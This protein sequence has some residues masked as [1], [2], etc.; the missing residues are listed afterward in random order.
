M[1][2]QISVTLSPV[3]T[4]ESKKATWRSI[5]DLLKLEHPTKTPKDVE[6]IIKRFRNLEYH[7][8]IAIRNHQQGLTETGNLIVQ[9]IK[10]NINGLFK[11]GGPATEVLG[12]MFGPR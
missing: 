8:K 1:K 2:D 5:A 3:V 4:K 11:S 9:N 12:G 6:A 10:H 7:G